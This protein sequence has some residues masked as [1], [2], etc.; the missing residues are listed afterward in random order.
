MDDT[1][2]LHYGPCIEIYRTGIHVAYRPLLG[3]RERLL[4]P[5]GGDADVDE[6]RYRPRRV[7]PGPPAVPPRPLVQREAELACLDLGDEGGARGGAELNSDV[8]A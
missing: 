2:G 5:R 6:L 8:R 1:Q 3:V 4:G 7:H